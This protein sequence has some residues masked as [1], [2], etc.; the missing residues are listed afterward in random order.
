M[1][2]KSIEKF[3]W[4]SHITTFRSQFKCWNSARLGSPEMKIYESQVY[5]N[6]W[7]GPTDLD[8][9]SLFK[10]LSLEMKM[11]SFDGWYCKAWL[12]WYIFWRSSG[13]LWSKSS[14]RDHHSCF[15]C[16]LSTSP[17]FRVKSML[18]SFGSFCN[19]PAEPSLQNKSF[20]RGS[21]SQIETH[22]GVDGLDCQH[23]SCNRPWH[24]HHRHH[25]FSVCFW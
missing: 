14:Q 24:R 3:K 23:H 5:F 6:F 20:V 19:G 25:C 1:C 17:V 22:S 4:I 2:L 11:F 7:T 8:F 12:C 13:A 18:M 9:Y 21:D 15:N 10:T 16:W